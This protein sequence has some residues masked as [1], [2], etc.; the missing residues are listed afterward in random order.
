MPRP[1]RGLCPAPAARAH[2][3]AVLPP[4]PL[5][6]TGN[7]LPAQVEAYLADVDFEALRTEAG[8]GAVRACLRERA[9]ASAPAAAAHE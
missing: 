2:T 8:A 4:A 1:A 6:S 3:T 9:C 7:P 5:R